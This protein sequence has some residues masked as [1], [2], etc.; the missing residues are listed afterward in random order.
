[1]KKPIRKMNSTILKVVNGD[2]V[3][4]TIIQQGMQ[5]SESTGYIADNCTNAILDTS[6]GALTLHS[7]K[8]VGVATFKAV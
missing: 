2:V 3:R 1:M 7:G 8:W 6:K 4:D 5:L